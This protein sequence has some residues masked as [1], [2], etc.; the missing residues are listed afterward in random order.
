MV[1]WQA[2]VHRETRRAPVRSSPSRCLLAS[3]STPTITGGL[4]LIP[5]LAT[6]IFRAFSVGVWNLPVLAALAAASAATLFILPFARA[7][8]PFRHHDYFIA[9]NG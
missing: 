3:P 9:Q 1:S 4:L 8:A 5:F 7:A 2:A 6:E